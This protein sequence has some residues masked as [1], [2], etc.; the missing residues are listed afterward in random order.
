[1]AFDAKAIANELLDI[2][3]G[4]KKEITPMKIQK[5][6]YFAHGWHLAVID[7]P[8]INEQ[9]E[10]WKFG[11]VIR[12]IYTAFREYGKAPIQ[13]H[14]TSFRL[15]DPLKFKIVTPKLDDSSQETEAKE[16][17]KKIWDV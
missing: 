3:W 6:V 4:E 17:L 9:V 5:L 16:L 13:D 14:A 2:A 12:T 8:L 7:R 15:V 1:M 10:A 11:P